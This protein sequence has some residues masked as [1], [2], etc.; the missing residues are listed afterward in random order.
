MLDFGLHKHMRPASRRKIVVQ[1][2]IA[3]VDRNRAMSE[4]NDESADDKT[5]RRAACRKKKQ[6]VDFRPRSSKLLVGCHRPQL[7]AQKRELADPRNSHL[8]FFSFFAPLSRSRHFEVISERNQASKSGSNTCRKFSLR[9]AAATAAAAARSL[10]GARRSRANICSA[11]LL[12]CERHGAQQ[13]KKT[14][15]KS[16]F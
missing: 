16:F 11:F 14:T 6:T 5:R 7:A 15:Q 12:I 10:S 3:I 4:R 9:A 2:A 1:A 13:T 8:F